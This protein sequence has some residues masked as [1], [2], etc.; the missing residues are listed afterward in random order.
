MS[1][2]YYRELQPLIIPEAS[3]TKPVPIE[4]LSAF[5]L[6]FD[7]SVPIPQEDLFL[8]KI[9]FAGIR[10]K[11]SWS[12]S[13]HD[14]ADTELKDAFGTLL[15]DDPGIEPSQALNVTEHWVRE[16]STTS[17]IPGRM[18]DLGADKIGENI[19]ALG[20]LLVRATG[21]PSI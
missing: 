3:H 15:I 9:L 11:E 21:V 2:A 20:L 13:A 14:A 17:W 6:T 1:N 16:S 12:V 18:I 4:V 5:G 8:A 10:D 7:L 19:D